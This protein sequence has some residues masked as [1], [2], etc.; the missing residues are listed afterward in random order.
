[1]FIVWWCLYHQRD[2][3]PGL[4]N[5]NHLLGVTHFLLMWR[6]HLLNYAEHFLNRSGPIPLRDQVGLQDHPHFCHQTGH[7]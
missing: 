5:T 2:Q 7:H 4:S 6:S 1:M 3:V